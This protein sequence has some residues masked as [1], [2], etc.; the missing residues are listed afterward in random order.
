VGRA[1]GP[2]LPLRCGACMVGRGGEELL[3]KHGW[4]G[5]R[6]QARAVR[7]SCVCLHTFWPRVPRVPR[8]PPP[9]WAL[10]ASHLWK[11][12]MPCTCESLGAL[13]AKLCAWGFITAACCTGIS[14]S[15]FRHP[16]PHP[17]LVQLH[18]PVVEL[19]PPLVELRLG[20]G[21]GLGAGVCAS[22]PCCW[23][24]VCV[25]PSHAAGQVCVCVCVPS[26]HAAGQVC[27]C[28]CVCVPSSH[29]AG[30]AL[31]HD[32]MLPAPAEAQLL[33]AF[34]HPTCKPA[35]AAAALWPLR[36]ARSA[37]ALHSHAPHALH[38]RESASAR[39][40]VHR[41]TCRW[42]SARE[43]RRTGRTSLA[44]R[45]RCSPRTWR[46]WARMGSSGQ[47][48]LAARRRRRRRCGRGGTGLTAAVRSSSE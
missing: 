3:R 36:T 19:P 2:A 22:F 9:A 42:W 33:P 21:V 37:A 11:P 12:S 25:P 43:A 45:H 26:S 34:C 41:H 7:G 39:L 40:P 6:L 15:C 5:A 27:V 30:L 32:L 14:R 24:G 48:S 44:A 16:D 1:A 20:P 47:L 38:L 28:V 18:P 4:A 17:P 31:S 35:H 13:L 8:V 10:H 23:A 46:P 29:A